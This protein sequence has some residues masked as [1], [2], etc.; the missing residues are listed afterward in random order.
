MSLGL[1]SQHSDQ[2]LGQE[3]GKFKD[4]LSNLVRFCLKKNKKKNNNNK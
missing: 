3:D 4:N 1:S 2:K